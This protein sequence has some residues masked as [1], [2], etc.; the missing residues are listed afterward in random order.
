MNKEI[1]AN[2]IRNMATSKAGFSLSDYT[3]YSDY[4]KDYRHY[5]KYADK[6][7]KFPTW[8]I[9]DILE[10]NTDENILE[11]T[12]RNRFSFKNNRLTYIA[13]QYHCTE[14]QQYLFNLI[15]DLK[16]GVQPWPNRWLFPY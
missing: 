4:R 5:K 7:R 6:T 2:E 14:Y 9:M 16:K 12:K 8:E 10:N 3:S 13:G 15:M 1:L 11:C